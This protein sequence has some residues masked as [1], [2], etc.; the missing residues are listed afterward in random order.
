MD[1]T[2]CFSFLSESLDRLLDSPFVGAVT[3]RD[4]AIL[5]SEYLVMRMGT[6]PL[7]PRF[8]FRLCRHNRQYDIVIEKR[9][10]FVA[11][12]RES[13]DNIVT[14]ITSMFVPWDM[15]S[16]PAF[17]ISVDVTED[18]AETLAAA[19]AE[20]FD[21]KQRGDDIAYRYEVPDEMDSARMSTGNDSVMMSFAEG[22]DEYY[23]VGPGEN[24]VV[25]YSPYYWEEMADLKKKLEFLDDVKQFIDARVPDDAV[26][27][28]ASGCTV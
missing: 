17:N 11:V 3:H 27:Y 2:S 10:E 1:G 23:G 9:V 13:N 21:F 12:H 18:E 22:P 14:F 16:A 28:T 8:W 25:H 7:L 20:E 26:D 24:L 4:E 5:D 15:G 6:N 19:I